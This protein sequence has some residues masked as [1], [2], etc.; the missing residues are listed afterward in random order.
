MSFASGFDGMLENESRQRVG[1]GH[2]TVSEWARREAT[3]PFANDR[4]GTRRRLF[5]W[6]RGRSVDAK[7]DVHVEHSGARAAWRTRVAGMASTTWSTLPCL[8]G[9]KAGLCALPAATAIDHMKLHTDEV[10]VLPRPVVGET[11]PPFFL[12]EF[13]SVYT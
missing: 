10:E 12:S 6:R 5:Q 2:V 9:V 1:A 7:V 11:A 8:A 4:G 13:F 3:A